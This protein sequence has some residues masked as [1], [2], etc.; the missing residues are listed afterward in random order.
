MDDEKFEQIKSVLAESEMIKMMFK[1]DKE[2]FEAIEDARN[3]QKLK[4]PTKYSIEVEDIEKQLKKA[5]KANKRIE[6]D[7]LFAN[8]KRFLYKHILEIEKMDIQ[9][10]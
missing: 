9:E 6:N 10:D 1:D 8:Y 3:L 2:F 7:I 4:T 5:I